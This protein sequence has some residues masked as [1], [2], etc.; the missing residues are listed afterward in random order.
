MNLATPI[1]SIPNIGPVYKKKLKR[2][3]IKT[4]NDLFFHFPHRY[5]DFSNLVSIAKLKINEV[6]TIYGQVLT[7]ENSR[8]WKR[9]MSITEAVI[10]DKTGAIKAMWFNPPYLTKT[11]RAEENVF[12]SGKVT[13]SKKGAYLSNP[14]YEKGDIKDLTHTGR[15]IPVYPET[16]GLSSRWIRYILKPLLV[17]LEN[18]IYETLPSTIRKE[19]NRMSIQQAL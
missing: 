19:H 2:L 12:L 1:E 18:Q 11:L 14:I 15:L 7:I 4:I 13:L 6:A 8:S 3:G 17:S 10:K 16:A 5:E 9:R